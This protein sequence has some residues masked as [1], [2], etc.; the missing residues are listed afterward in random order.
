[1]GLL[2]RPLQL[3]D[4]PQGVNIQLGDAYAMFFFLNLCGRKE[5]VA[6]KSN[7]FGARFNRSCLYFFSGV[8]ERFIARPVTLGWLTEKAFATG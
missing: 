8:Y 7:A 6:L 2:K 3:A 4:R 1:D 5:I